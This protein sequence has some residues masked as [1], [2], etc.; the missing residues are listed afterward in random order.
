MMRRPPRSTRT[1]TLFPYTTLFRSGRE[2]VAEVLQV[3]VDE[4]QLVGGE[5]TEQARQD[6]GD[7]VER[8]QGDRVGVGR[9]D[10][11]D[12]RVERGVTG[13]VGGRGDDL[14]AGGLEGLRDVLGQAGAVR[15]VQ[16]EDRKST[17]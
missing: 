4:V 9:E 11:A 10:L 13:V 8:D 2:C 1:D 16:H 7:L 6:R 14:A 3:A 17:R 5:L 15:V 12:L